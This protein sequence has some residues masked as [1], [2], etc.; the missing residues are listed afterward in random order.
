MSV[1][2]VYT[3]YMSISQSKKSKVATKARER[4][5][6]AAARENSKG[7]FRSFVWA[8]HTRAATAFIQTG[9]AKHL[10]GFPCNAD[11]APYVTN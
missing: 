2:A 1:A 5:V 8:E 11:K 10:R 4:F 7:M 3:R 6:E 9:E